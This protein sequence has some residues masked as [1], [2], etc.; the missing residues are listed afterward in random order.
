MKSGNVFAIIIVLCST[1]IGQVGAMPLTLGF[2]CITNNNP[3]NALIGETQFFLDISMVDAM[4][5]K[6]VFNNT[7]PEPSSIARVYFDGDVLEGMVSLAGSAGVSF[8]LDASPPVL[9]GGNSVTPAFVV[10]LSAGAVAPPPHNGVNPG[11]YLE[12]VCLLAAGK[13]AIDVEQDLGSGAL[14]VGLHAISIG[15]TADSE[16]FMTPEPAAAALLAIGTLYL[17]PRRRRK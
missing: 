1:L 9:P 15:I 7:G 10:D 8:D 6:F 17:R 16:A 13:T 12:V 5:V 3:A 11:E 14:R 4:H 2:E